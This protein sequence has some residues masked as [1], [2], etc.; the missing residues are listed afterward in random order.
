MKRILKIILI[1]FLCLGIGFA[2]GYGFG[3]LL[4]GGTVEHMLTDESA[5]W[6]D[7]VFLVISSMVGVFIGWFLQLIIH[8]AGPLVCGLI[9]GYKFVSFRVLSY[10]LLKEEGKFKVKK[11]SLSGTEGQC[12][13]SPPDIPAE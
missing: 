6:K 5:K 11:F 4:D 13:L 7:I 2:I 12:L 1:V 9:S 10:T 3:K 8:E